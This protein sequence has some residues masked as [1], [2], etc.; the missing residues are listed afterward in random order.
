[1]AKVQLR[2]VY[3]NFDLQHTI[4]GVEL[5]KSSSDRAEASFI[6]T[7]RRVRG[8]SF[9]DNRTTGVFILRKEE[10]RWKLYDQRIEDVEYLE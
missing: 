6:L 1:M 3:R 7:T 2:D 5:L 10:G 8:P 9:R 4:T